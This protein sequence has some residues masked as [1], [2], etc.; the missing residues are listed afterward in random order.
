M[1]VTSDWLSLWPVG[2]ALEWETFG[3][4]GAGRPVDY[5]GADSGVPAEAR[6]GDIVTTPA[7]SVVLA[8][9]GPVRLTD[10]G[11][12]VLRNSLCRGRAGARAPSP[13]RSPSLTSLPTAAPTGPSPR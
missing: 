8:A 4:A 7:E 3:I 11:L 6:V 9:K 13:T 5:A 12:A 2:G 10:F 1:P